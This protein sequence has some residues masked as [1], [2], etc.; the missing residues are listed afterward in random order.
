QL[1]SGEIEV[2]GKKVPTAP[3]S[4]L[5]GARKI[6]ETL[7]EWIQSGKFHLGEPVDH[8]PSADFSFNPEK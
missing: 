7:K 8:F 4:S 5:P 2:A 1:K 6:A 3:L